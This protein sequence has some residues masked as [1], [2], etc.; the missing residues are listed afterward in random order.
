MKAPLPDHRI[1]FGVGRAV[2]ALAGAMLLLSGC[3]TTDH[4]KDLKV[5]P[6]PA[7]KNRQA[8]ER[9]GDV[10]TELR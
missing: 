10:A 9:L 7:E 1:P 8:Q 2:F 3:E 4:T 6:T 5:Y